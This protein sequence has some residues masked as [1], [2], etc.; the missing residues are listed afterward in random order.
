MRVVMLIAAAVLAAGCGAA[1][2]PPLSAEQL[3]AAVVAL[4]QATGRTMHMEWDGT[5]STAELEGRSLP[6][7]AVLDFAGADYAG[8][9]SVP[10]EAVKGGIDVPAPYTEIALVDGQAYQRTSYQGFWQQV[11]ARP[12]SFDPFGG[13]TPADIVYVGQE[14]RDGA[15]VHHLR[16]ADASALAATLFGGPGGG[17]PAPVRFSA[18]ESTFDFYVDATGTPLSAELVLASPSAPNDFRGP[19]VSSTYEFSNWGADIDII[20]PPS[21]R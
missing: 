3:P 13:L 16:L 21:P 10:R 20:S 1:P 6:F 17:M 12:R 7:N 15:D 9:I 11:D 4:T 8:T 19:S 2:A 14:K 18:A 5:Y